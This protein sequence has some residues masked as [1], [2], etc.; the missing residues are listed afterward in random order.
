[1][2]AHNKCHGIRSINLENIACFGLCNPEV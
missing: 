1:L 2:N